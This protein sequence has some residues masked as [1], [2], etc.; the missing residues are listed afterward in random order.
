MRGKRKAVKERN[1][2]M[3]EE[4]VRVNEVG[5]KE[6]RGESSREEGIGQ[7]DVCVRV[8]DFV[9]VLVCKCVSV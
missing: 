9:S 3:Q 7:S 8:C 6:L 2:K 1:L 4:A 5:D